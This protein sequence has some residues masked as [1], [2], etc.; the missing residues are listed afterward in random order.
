MSKY[1]DGYRTPPRAQGSRSAAHYNDEARGTLPFPP[2]KKARFHYSSSK[3][4]TLLQH[5]SWDHEQGRVS[6]TTS[7]LLSIPPPSLSLKMRRPLT[8]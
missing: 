5:T 7:S 6:E 4:L 1:E 3:G 2:P 8:T